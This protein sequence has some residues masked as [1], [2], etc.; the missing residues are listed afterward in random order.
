MI[1]ERNLTHRIRAAMAPA[2]PVPA[3]AYESA[4]VDVPRIADLIAFDNL[5]PQGSP[6]IDVIPGSRLGRPGRSEH[7]GCS[8]R[9]GRRSPTWRVLA[10]ALSGVAVIGV[11][12]SL[13][14]VSSAAPGRSAAGVDNAA[15]AKMPSA[16]LSVNG[17]PGHSGVIFHNSRTGAAIASMK[18]SYLKGTVPVVASV[19]TRKQEKFVVVRWTSASGK[20]VAET[21]LLTLT[22]GK[23][24][25]FPS[26]VL[27][28]PGPATK[29][30]GAVRCGAGTL[31]ALGV[32]RAGGGTTPQIRLVTG[33][34]KSW[35]A[36][37]SSALVSD[38]SCVGKD[39]LAFVLTDPKTGLG[40]VRRL[41]LTGSS[42]GLLSSSVLARS[43][44]KTGAIGSA[45]VSRSGGT[46]IATVFGPIRHR[47]SSAFR[48]IRLVAIGPRTGKIDKTFVTMY[49]G[50]FA[51][52][53]NPAKGSSSRAVTRP[54]GL[55]DDERGCQVV[56]LDRTGQHAL[57]NCLGLFRLDNGTFTHL[58]DN[59]GKF[60]PQ[61]ITASW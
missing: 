2:N 39:K 57:T 12:V 27:G 40:Q 59:Q 52:Q 1:N 6:G 53:V 44:G 18:M 43:G 51:V 32:P 55:I 13:A 11:A 54:S 46:I 36:P 26:T 25:S 61:V 24:V 4:E 14:L 30:Q 22:H 9:A 15:L 58:P 35:S 19:G 41:D 37:G 20:P 7:A 21:E 50:G 23:I 60:G 8:E 42:N 3:T 48:Q 17:L 31:I 49:Q 56:S 16:Y 33:H 10:P 28:L 34:F 38:L 29:I 47:G 5:E 45:L